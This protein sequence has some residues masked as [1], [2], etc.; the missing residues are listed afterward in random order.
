[1]ARS[2]L[3]LRAIL[4]FQYFLLLAGMRQCLAQPCQKQ[5][6][7][8]MARR[9]L[10]KMKSG[11]PGM[12]AWRR[13]PLIFAERK[14]ETRMSSVALLPRERTAAMIRERSG[15]VNVSATRASMRELACVR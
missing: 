15:F 6:S 2:R 9:C 8:K 14:S 5:P 1:M 4:A 13:Q 11:R 7:T 12:L 3:M 10:G